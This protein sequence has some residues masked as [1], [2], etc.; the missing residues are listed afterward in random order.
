MKE[1]YDELLICRT[2][3]E[4]TQDDLAKGAITLLIDLT[5]KS[6]YY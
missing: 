2:L 5:G 1:L 3:A 4:G 6:S